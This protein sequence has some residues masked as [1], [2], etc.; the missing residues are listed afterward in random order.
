MPSFE[1]GI[2]L[3]ETKGNIGTGNTA[4]KITYKNFYAVRQNGD[5]PVLFLL[6]DDYLPIGLK[7]TCSPVELMKNYQLRP[8]LQE[9]FQAILPKLGGPAA[10]PKQA[11]APTKTAEPK[12][13]PKPAVQEFTPAQAFA[14]PAKPKAEEGQGS[15]DWWEMTSR[16]SNNLFKK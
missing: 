11:P 7:E 1:E 15:G 13:Q 2:Y 9:K 4:S 3:Q 8:D 16:G 14:K 6:D 12:P 5:M 10:A